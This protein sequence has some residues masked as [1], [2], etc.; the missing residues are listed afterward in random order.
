M[1]VHVHLA[2]FNRAVAVQRELADQA[3]SDFLH[4]IGVP[5]RC[6]QRPIPS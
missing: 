2:H 1:N 3:L 4:D 6:F 5:H